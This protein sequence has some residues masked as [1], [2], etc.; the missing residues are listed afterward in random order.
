VATAGDTLQY[1]LVV[2]NPGEV[3]IPASAVE[4]VDEQC[5]PQPP[6]LVSKEP[7][8]TPGTL[9]PGDEWTYRCSRDTRAPDDCEPTTVPNEASVSATVR[10]T[11]V[12]D[13][14]GIST[15]LLCPDNPVPPIPPTPGP[16]GPVVPPGPRPPD[17]GDA[18]KA[19]LIFQRAIQGCIGRRVPR[20]NL[21]GVRIASVRIYVNGRF[22]RGLT[23]DVLQR[24]HRPRVTLTPGQ[25]YRIRVGVTFQLG[26]DSPPVTL[27]GRIRICARPPVACPSAV[28][29]EPGARAACAGIVRRWRRPT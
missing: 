10:G 4:V 2:T 1:R 14:D 15:I 23:L 13:D 11:T 22:I 19:G 9:D 20:V 16:P 12:S 29:E 27:A 26:T 24:A 5:E 25:R 21:S 6:E 17:A 18:G 3:P 8:T 7:A 28:R